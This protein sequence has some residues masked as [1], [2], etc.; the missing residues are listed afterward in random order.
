MMLMF[1]LADICSAVP[2]APILS[3]QLEQ[4]VQRYCT[5]NEDLAE[6]QVRAQFRYRNESTQPVLLLRKPHDV[7]YIRLHLEAPAEAKKRDYSIS[8]T[9]ISENLFGPAEYSS[10]DFVLLR[11]SESSSETDSFSFPYKK[12]SG[13]IEGDLIT[14]GTYSVSVLVSLWPGTLEQATKMQSV[15]AVPN[16]MVW[17]R[18]LWSKPIRI[19]IHSSQPTQACGAN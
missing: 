12:P 7:E 13:T 8:T 18:P 10:S 3:I 6:I 2:P 16:A 11:P 14:D 17:T 1:L 15:L 5:G 19:E 9:T 4:V